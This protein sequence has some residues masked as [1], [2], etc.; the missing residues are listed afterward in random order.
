MIAV[1][2]AVTSAAPMPGPPPRRPEPPLPPPVSAAGPRASETAARS[3]ISHVRHAALT[4]TDLAATAAFY[5]GIWGLYRVGSDEDV[6]YL[7]AVGSPEPYVLRI[8]QS[9]ERRT[10]LIAFGAHDAAAVDALAESL[11]TAG[12]QLV[13]EPGPV[14]GPGAGYGFRFFDPEGRQIE[15]SSDV[16][17][18]PFRD[19]E[20]G[21]SVPRELSHIVLN[22]PNLPVLKAF[23]EG[24][25]GLRLSDWLEDRMCFLR[26]STD[27]HS[28][29]IAQAPSPGMNH[30]SFEMRDI[31]E[32]MRGTGRLTRN[33]HA[34]GW[35]PG[36]HSSGNN[37]YSYFA[38]PDN[39]VVE[40][41]TALEKIPDEDSWVPRV[42]PATPEYA[43]RWGTAGPGEDLF[44][45]WM[46]TPPEAGLWVPSPV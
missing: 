13:S 46:T 34:P 7:G 20:P 4:T 21:E 26:C 17:A 32:Y 43:D 45:L 5:E 36:R 29:A 25:F 40:Y 24:H 6:V 22:S 14:T 41:T 8:R 9:A 16:A 1:D 31:D 37:V 3:P 30:V 27:H 10:D 39:F 33:G 15:V 28:L 18:K 44:A 12:V 38:G 19:V 42:W 35:G 11:G 2:S 23:Y